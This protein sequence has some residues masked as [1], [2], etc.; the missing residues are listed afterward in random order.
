MIV[1]IKEKLVMFHETDFNQKLFEGEIPLEHGM[2]Y[3]SYLFLDEK[4]CL[5]DTSARE[6]KD[7]FF[8]EL[9]ETLNGRELDYIIIHHIEPDHTASI[10][11]VMKKYPKAQIY[12]SMIGSTFFKNFFPDLCHLKFNIIKEGDTLPLG[13]HT[14]RFISAPMVHWPEVMMSYE[15]N[16]QILFSADAFGSFVTSSNPYECNY[17]N[18]ALLLSESRRYFTNV[19]SKYT[20]SVLNLV[21]KIKTLPIKMIL[22]LHGLIHQQNIPT[23]F[24][25]YG[26]WCTYTPEEDGVLILY[27]SIY[28]HTKEAALYLEKG[29]HA[30][31]IKTTTRT[32]NLVD[33][34]YALSDSFIYSKI[35]LLAPTFNVG[36]YPKMEIYLRTLI[37]HGVQNKHFY[38]IENGSWAPQAKELMKKYIGELSNCTID[39]L[40]LTIKSALKP[41]D[42]P[43]LDNI[44]KNV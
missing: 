24:S 18:K 28:G 12:I 4:T 20:S 14:L 39:P 43:I 34:S 37:E 2:S 30:R 36:L 15:E 33:V 23:L 31:G 9:S 27:A 8:K 21:T 10:R 17:E 29:L 44:I 22:S 1:N 6:V 42:Y 7:T 16:N 25:W 32:L 19:I 5:L 38:L 41:T 11:D 3:N 40:S 13:S 35:I 26:K